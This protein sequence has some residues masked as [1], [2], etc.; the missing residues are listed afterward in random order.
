MACEN[1]TLPAPRGGRPALPSTPPDVLELIDR[2]VDAIDAR[3]AFEPDT[4]P[5]L[6]AASVRE[7]ERE[8]AHRWGLLGRPMA[9]MAGGSLR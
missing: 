3:E 2:L 8:L 1:P 7:I 4:H 9:S 6:A 5:W